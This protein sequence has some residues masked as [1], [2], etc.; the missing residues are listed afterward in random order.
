MLEDAP[1]PRDLSDLL[2]RVEVLLREP[3]DFA[4]TDPETTVRKVRLLAAVAT[5]VNTLALSDYGGRVGAERQPG[6][7]EQVVA[8]AFQTFAGVDPH[9][10]PFSKAAMLMRGITQGHPFQDANKRTGFLVATYFVEQIGY[11]LVEPVPE[12]EIIDLAL[13]ISSGQLRDVAEIAAE[14]R[15][16]YRPRPDE[17]GPLPPSS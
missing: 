9:P 7:V 6:L 16:F 10:T 11:E 5:Y 13:R 15:P 3:L 2:G 17:H 12:Q 4:Q 8:A 1:L 14:L